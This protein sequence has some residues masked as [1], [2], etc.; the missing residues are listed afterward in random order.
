[1]L[2][3]GKFINNRVDDSALGREEAMEINISCTGSRC[4]GVGVQLQYCRAD[5][6]VN[7]PEYSTVTDRTG[8]DST[9]SVQSM[10]KHPSDSLVRFGEIY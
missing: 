10:S 7:P 8:Q 3:L 2:P 1:M 5:K 4:P 6:I 9:V